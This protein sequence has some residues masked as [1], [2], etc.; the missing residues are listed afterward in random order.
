[1]HGSKK[2]GVGGDASKIQEMNTIK[3]GPKSLK[4][5]IN[6]KNNNEFFIIIQIIRI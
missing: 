5:K 2:E 3:G 1:M 6:R 4:F